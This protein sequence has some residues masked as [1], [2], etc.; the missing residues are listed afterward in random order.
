M[1][2]PAFHPPHCRRARIGIVKM[3]VCRY[4]T[5]VAPL[6]MEPDGFFVEGEFFTSTQA[7]SVCVS[8]LPGSVPAPKIEGVLK[9][10][11]VRFIAM[12]F[13]SVAKFRK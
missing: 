5:Y 8:A 9:S 2:L 11:N 12:H 10:P 4:V 3:L 7:S 1:Y 13:Y 6:F